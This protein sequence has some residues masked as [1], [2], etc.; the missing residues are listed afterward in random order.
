MLQPVRFRCGLDSLA[1][2]NIDE[3]AC[4]LSSDFG[5]I[6]LTPDVSE[7]ICCVKSRECLYEYTQ[8]HATYAEV[9]SI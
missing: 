4:I 8:K 1:R 5:K 9:N 7:R 2:R 6:R 3:N